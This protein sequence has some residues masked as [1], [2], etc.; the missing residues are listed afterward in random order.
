[1]HILS[2]FKKLTKTKKYKCDEN[3]FE[4]HYHLKSFCLQNRSGLA[5]QKFIFTKPVESYF[6]STKQDYIKSRSYV[7]EFNLDSQAS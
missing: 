1:M 2:Q 3:T 4:L 6:M 5:S 7:P